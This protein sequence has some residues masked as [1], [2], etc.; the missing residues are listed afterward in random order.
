MMEFEMPRFLP[1]AT[2]ALAITA[3][4]TAGANPAGVN[5]SQLAQVKSACAQMGLNT[6]ELPFDD[7]VTVLSRSVASSS[8]SA[9][10]QQ[11]R[12]AC[13]EAGLQPGSPAFA[14]CVLDHGYS[15]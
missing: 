15:R 1:I 11:S 14:N 5:N 10:V 9:T 2:L 8:A 4:S 7:C 3:C 12:G 13:A 6:S